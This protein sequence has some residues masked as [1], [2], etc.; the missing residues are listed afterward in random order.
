MPF[1]GDSMPKRTYQPKARRRLRKHGFRARMET[2]G[3][4]QVLKN[5]WAK[6]RWKMTASDELR[7]RK[8]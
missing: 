4:R 6:G 8:R 7:G 2:R 1:L 5:R 3:G